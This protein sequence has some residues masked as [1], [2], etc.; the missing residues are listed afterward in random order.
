MNTTD[1]TEIPNPSWAIGS[2]CNHLHT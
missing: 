1:F 2:V